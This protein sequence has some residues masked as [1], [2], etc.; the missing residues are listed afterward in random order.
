MIVKQLILL[1]EW[2][3][4]RVVRSVSYGYCLQLSV[5]QHL[6][7]YGSFDGLK[8]IWLDRR[9]LRSPHLG[10]GLEPIRL[11]DGTRLHMLGE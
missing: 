2:Y 6:G 8:S 1:A 10:A 4:G 3:P 7:L 11:G 5:K 9:R